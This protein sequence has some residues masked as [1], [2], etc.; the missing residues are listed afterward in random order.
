VVLIN[1]LRANAEI[2]A[3]SPLDMPDILREVA[4]HSLDIHT[5]SRPVRQHLCRFDEE[6]RGFI[7][8]EVPKLLKAE[9]IEEVFHPEWLPNLVL[10]K[11]KGGKWR[12]CIDYTGLNKACPKV[13]YPLCRT[14]QIIDSTSG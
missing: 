6:K 11:K 14:N 7:G 10:V 9:F 13:P 8:E 2:F 1:F 12:M 4:E 5:G 3:W